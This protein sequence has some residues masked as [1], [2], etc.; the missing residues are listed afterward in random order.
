MCAV[1]VGVRRS[2]KSLN[3]ESPV[4]DL[5]SREMRFVDNSD[6]FTLVSAELCSWAEFS[7]SQGPEGVLRKCSYFTPDQVRTLNVKFQCAVYPYCVP[8]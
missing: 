2:F 3:N 6:E 4:G 8:Y 5:F 7:E 1:T